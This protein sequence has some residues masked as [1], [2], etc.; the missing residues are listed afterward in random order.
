[1]NSAARTALAAAAII[2]LLLVSACGSEEPTSS[3]PTGSSTTN[4]PAPIGELGPFLAA[5]DDAGGC[6][7]ALVTGVTDGIGAINTYAKTGQGVPVDGTATVAEHTGTSIK[8]VPSCQFTIDPGNTDLP[9]TLIIGGLTA[10]QNVLLTKTTQPTMEVED[11]VSSTDGDEC[12]HVGVD[13]V[14]AAADSI[15]SANDADMDCVVNNKSHNG[16]INVSSLKVSLYGDAGYARSAD[17]YYSA[18]IDPQARRLGLT[19]D[20]AGVFS[21]WIRRGPQK[22]TSTHFTLIVG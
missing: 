2:P 3:S 21:N 17:G 14:A 15:L 22:G 19:S 11:G 1:M 10:G 16:I 4:I 6:S 9:D 7:D 12:P 13:R 18:A 20:L 5:I 8:G